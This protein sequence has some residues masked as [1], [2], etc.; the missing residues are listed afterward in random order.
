MLAIV[1]AYD[2]KY[3]ELEDAIERI[4]KT[5]ETIQKLQKW[6]GHLYNWYNTRTLEPLNPRYV[7]TVDNGN[8]IGYL[9]TV[10][11]FLTN[12]E[13]NLKVSVPNTSGYIENNEDPIEAAKRELKEENA[14]YAELADY[15]KVSLSGFKR[16]IR[17]NIPNLP[18]RRK[19][20]ND[21]E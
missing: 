18:S 2:L 14:T 20:K 6:N 16:F 21:T 15:Y 9:Y 12:T 8:F 4:S 17:E 1:S 13:K 10:K 5:L 7:S 11:Q 19:K 3:I